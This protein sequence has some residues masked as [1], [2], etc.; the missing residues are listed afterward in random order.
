M[1]VFTMNLGKQGNMNKG[2]ETNL[3]KKGQ[4]ETKRESE[5]IRVKKENTENKNNQ[6]PI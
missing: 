1:V 5:A 3:R 2:N 4:R 6:R